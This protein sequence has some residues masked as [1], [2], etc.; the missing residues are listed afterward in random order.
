MTSQTRVPGTNAARSWAKRT[1]QTSSQFQTAA[2]KR[3]KAGQWLSSAHVGGNPHEAFPSFAGLQMVSLPQAL[4]LPAGDCSSAVQSAGR[5][6]PLPVSQRE[7]RGQRSR[8]CE[9]GRDAARGL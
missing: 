6:R 8:N 7:P 2:L 3:R 1:R 5:Q 9:S 4:S